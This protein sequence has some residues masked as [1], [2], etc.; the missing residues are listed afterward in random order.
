M[1]IDLAST[2]FAFDAEWYWRIIEANGRFGATAARAFLL[3]IA[4]LAQPRFVIDGIDV[5]GD[6]RVQFRIDGKPVALDVA[7]DRAR[8]AADRFVIDL[9]HHLRAVGHAFALVVARRYQ[10]RGV[11]LPRS[12]LADHARDPLVIAPSDR[13]G[14]RRFARGTTNPL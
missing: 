11:L 12:L 1:G 6:D 2:G 3:P 13:S 9:N 7:V 10:L 14:W 8:Y 5:E 4:R